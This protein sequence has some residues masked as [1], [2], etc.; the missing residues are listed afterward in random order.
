MHVFVVGGGDSSAWAVQ[1]EEFGREL[2]VSWR[3]AATPD[4]PEDATVPTAQFVEAYVAKGS[5][6]TLV[7]LEGARVVGYAMADL[8]GRCRWA[9]A[10]PDYP[11]AFDN[12]LRIIKARDGRVY[13]RVRNEMMR[14]TILTVCDWI[15]VLDPGDPTTI[16]G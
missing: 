1:I 15:S 12:M 5:T 14:E 4:I 16:G 8:G 9:G 2:D 10:H 11:E 3:C 7:A 6:L 13:G